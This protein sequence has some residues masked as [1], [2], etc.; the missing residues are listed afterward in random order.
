LAEVSAVLKRMREGGLLGAMV[1]IPLYR[2]ISYSLPSLLRSKLLISARSK[3]A[4]LPSYT[5]MQSTGLTP[6]FIGLTWV[7]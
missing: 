3:R 1:V 7:H 5:F 4:S 2:S 6:S